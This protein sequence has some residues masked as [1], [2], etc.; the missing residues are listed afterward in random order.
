MARVPSFDMSL[1]EQR[2]ELAALRVDMSVAVVR[3]KNPFNVGTIIRVA[4]SFMVRE[5]FLIGSEPYYERASM[6]M[7]RYENIVKCA[8]EDAFLEAV[9]GRPLVSVERDAATTTIWQAEFPERCV[10]IF[11]SE[12]DGVPDKLLAASSHVLSIPMYGINH[13]FPVSV[14]AGMVLCEWA[15]RRDPR[16]GVCGPDGAP[17]TRPLV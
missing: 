16:G 13:S 17:G 12:N 2:R 5:I 11:G 1:D 15:R 10:L 7:H 6:G 14:A 8:D 9:A 3:A 4:H